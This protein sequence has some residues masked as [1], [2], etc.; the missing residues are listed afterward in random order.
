MH[1]HPEAPDGHVGAVAALD[2]G[3]AAAIDSVIAAARRHD[4]PDRTTSA[5]ELAHELLADQLTHSQLAC[6]LAALA[7]HVAR[8]PEHTLTPEPDTRLRPAWWARVRELLAV[9]VRS[10]KDFDAAVEGAIE[11]ASC[12][13]EADQAVANVILGRYLAC[14]L[15]RW[16]L[17][18][19]LAA[20]AVHAIRPQPVAVS[21]GPGRLQARL[22]QLRA[23]A[24]RVDAGAAQHASRPASERR[25]A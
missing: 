6:A 21:A 22:A 17:A 2:R 7:L 19:S 3:A 18:F 15:H 11:A 9:P 23:A 24:R 16:Q 1:H 13:N 4:S 5:V 20:L 14:R 25:S 8:Q 10:G 12:F